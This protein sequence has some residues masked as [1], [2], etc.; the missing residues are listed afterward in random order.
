MVLAMFMTH[1]LD[2]FRK[3]DLP[4]LVS[5]SIY[6]F[7]P[8]HTN[9]IERASITLRNCARTF[10][11]KCASQNNRAERVINT[12]QSKP[13]RALRLRQKPTHDVDT[14]DPSAALF[15]L[16]GMSG[17]P[18]CLSHRRLKSADLQRLDPIATASADSAMV[19]RESGL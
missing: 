3:R 14:L 4:H 9:V 7:P 15:I 13:P 18:S 12:W 16:S 8:E 5:S 6:L 10:D 17:R 2:V 11:R 1:G 19:E